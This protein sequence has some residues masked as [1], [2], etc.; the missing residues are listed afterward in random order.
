MVR[1]S[2]GLGLVFVLAGCSFDSVSPSSQPFDSSGFAGSRPVGPEPSG[3]TGFVGEFMPPLPGAVFTA[4]QTPPPV[5]GGTL[6]ALRDQ[7]T[8]I[9][10]DPDRDQVLVVDLTHMAVTHTLTLEAHAEPGRAADD[11]QGHVHLVL[12]GSGQLLTF[13]P[14]TGD[15]LGTRNVC[16]YP[17]GV[18][19]SDSE[20][21]VHVA[22]AEGKLV[23][24]S[25]TASVATP[26]RSLT[27]DR[28]LRDIVVTSDGLWVS[29]FRSAEILRLDATGKLLSRTT[30]PSA[31]G[32]LGESVSSVAWRM[33]AG[34]NGGVVVVHQRAFA[35]E[36]VPSPGGYGSSG[37]QG[38][39]VGSA[40]TTVSENGTAMGTSVALSAPLPVDV[41]Q[42][43][44][45]G[46]LLIASATIEHPLQP[47]FMP[48][49]LLLR[50]ADLAFDKAPT[51]DV[52]VPILAPI[53]AA[54]NTTTVP[55]GQLVAVA[56]VGDTPL[57]QFRE[58]SQ[59]VFG[60]QGLSLP[61]NSVEDTGNTLFHLQTS[62]GLACASCH[63]EG[64]E[65]GHVWNFTGFG[66]RRTQSLRG[67]LL[68]SE[69]FHWDGAENDFTAL[70]TD[71]MQGRMGGPSLTADQ[72]TALAGYVD[73]FPALP[74]PAAAPSSSVDRGKTLFNDAN[75]G[76]ATCHSGPRFSNNQT[77]DVGN[78]SGNLQVPGLIGLW[79]R[80]PYLHDGC[81][82]TL[83]DRFTRC[84]TPKHGNLAG[85]TEAD[86]GSL[87]DYL[88]TL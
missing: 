21:V 39:I 50:P 29:R 22:C 7:K 49:T 67:G 81:A 51:G 36:V 68:G 58:P 47:S 27:L 38:G 17:R 30:L 69:P 25:T 65:D 19:V 33:V 87:S 61:G 48:R 88:E 24:L 15:V 10:A 18:A 20:N 83:G 75:V 8:A 70:T 3:G 6:L 64:Q 43:A 5:S 60:N 82:K 28:D 44:T 45:S 52:F 16:A 80:A 11:A 76:C 4:A 42:S 34:A 71:V 85:L 31:K 57:M 32:M 73:H 46:Q 26:T 63:P 53:D 86:L 37:V 54:S 12:R 2:W 41:A 59:L 72:T 66:P 1:Q 55:N 14:A 40:I 13:D 79:A 56:F 62:S 78:A 74:A 77:M 35:G 9:V 23:T 84:N